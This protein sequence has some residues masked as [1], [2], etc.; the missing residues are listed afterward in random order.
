MTFDDLVKM[1]GNANRAANALKVPRST[2]Y[3]WKD[4]GIPFEQQFRIQM[5]TKGKLK[6]AMPSI[7]G[8]RA[9]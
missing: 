8:R 9:A 6:A 7:N 2:F 1:Y 3:Q 5:K 4:A